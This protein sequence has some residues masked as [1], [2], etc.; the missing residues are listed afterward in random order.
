MEGKKQVDPQEVRLWLRKMYTC[1]WTYTEDI[2]TIVCDDQEF[3]IAPD[4]LDLE[5]KLMLK[6]ILYTIEKNPVI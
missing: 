3:N 1:K 6:R 2:I 4:Q 5:E